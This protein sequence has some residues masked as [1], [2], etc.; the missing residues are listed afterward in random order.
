MPPLL[1]DFTHARPCKPFCEK[2]LTLP[3]REG[4]VRNPDGPYINHHGDSKLSSLKTTHESSLVT[5]HEISN[6]LIF[7]CF[8]CLQETLYIYRVFYINQNTLCLG[9]YFCYIKIR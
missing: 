2:Y 1:A 7:L 4:A 8:C 9:T 5:A 6:T 3:D